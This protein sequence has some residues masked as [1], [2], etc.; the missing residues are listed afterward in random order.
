[1]RTTIDFNGFESLHW[2]DED[3]MW[4]VGEFLRKNGISS[5]FT[6]TLRFTIQYLE[7]VEPIP[8]ADEWHDA[9]MKE[10]AII[11]AS[12]GGHMEPNLEKLAAGEGLTPN[13]NP[14]QELKPGDGPV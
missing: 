11:K 3:I 9:F 13:M 8:G 6:G 4:K 10:L 5:E 1:M 12:S 7:T 14:Q 2:L